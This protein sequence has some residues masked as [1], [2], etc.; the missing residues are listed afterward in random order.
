MILRSS[1]EVFH[2]MNLLRHLGERILFHEIGN[3]YDEV[4]QLIDLNTIVETAW[5]M[6]QSTEYVQ[7]KR[8]DKPSNIIIQTWGKVWMIEIVKAAWVEEIVYH[9]VI[10]AVGVCQEQGCMIETIPEKDHKNN[11]YKGNLHIEFIIYS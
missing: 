5:E 11:I 7:G 2:Q 4:I 8:I 6:I 3:V 1:G 9:I 10:V